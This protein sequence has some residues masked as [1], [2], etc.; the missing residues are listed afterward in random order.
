MEE[1]GYPCKLIVV[2]RY[3][4][5]ATAIADEIGGKVLHIDTTATSRR[6][7]ICVIEKVGILDDM[8]KTADAA[9]IGGTFIDIGG[10]SMW[11]AA[12]YG[13]PLFFGSYTHTQKESCTLL[14]E[15]QVGFPVADGD[16]LARTMFDVVKENPISFFNAQ[17]RF[18]EATNK[19]R[20]IVEP[21][22]P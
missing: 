22:L 20:S 14:T 13:I 12:C 3:S 19:T 15:A 17:Q 16:E 5:E 18:I 11:D 6:W 8:Y 2:P 4:S 1:L 21:L 7:E 10:H 9:I